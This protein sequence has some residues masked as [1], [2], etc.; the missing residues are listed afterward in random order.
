M[1]WR[2]LPLRLPGQRWPMAWRWMAAACRPW[3]LGV[4]VGVLARRQQVLLV[5][6]KRQPAQ[7]KAACLLQAWPWVAPKVPPW[8]FQ[9][10]AAALRLKKPPVQSGGFAN[11]W[12]ISKVSSA[13]RSQSLQGANPL[14][15]TYRKKPRNYPPSTRVDDLAMLNRM[16][17]ADIQFFAFT[18]K[19]AFEI[20]FNPPPEWP[21]APGCS[22]RASYG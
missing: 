12:Q 8:R 21:L 16:V 18:C 10:T 19:G 6:A 14:N 3:R 9:P 4:L 2:R 1:H 17:L 15:A 20:Y 7:V 13:R 22:E 5:F 11:N